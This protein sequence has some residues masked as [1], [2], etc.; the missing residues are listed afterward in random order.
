MLKR[1]LRHW[2]FDQPDSFVL[3]KI[4]LIIYTFTLTFFLWLCQQII[5][6]NIFMYKYKL[7][8]R[9]MLLTLIIYK[10]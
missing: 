9:M 4:N 6:Y 7:F 2:R 5:Y 10:V 8:Y 1:M 3:N